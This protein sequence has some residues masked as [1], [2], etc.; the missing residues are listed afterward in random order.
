MTTLTEDRQKA[1][2]WYSSSPIPD[3]RNQTAEQLI[4]AG[5][6]DAVLRFIR[7]IEARSSG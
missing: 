2:R 6:S 3:L 5:K 4:D 7:S 1:E